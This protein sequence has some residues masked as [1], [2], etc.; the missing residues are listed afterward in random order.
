MASPHGRSQDPRLA[1]YTAVRGIG[2]GSYGEVF[3]VRHKGEK[4]QVR[5]EGVLV[6]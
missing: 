2:R 5:V 6:S 4:K 3:L 1:P